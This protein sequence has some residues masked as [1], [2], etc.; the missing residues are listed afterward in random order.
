MTVLIYTDTSKQ[1]GDPTSRS[2][3]IRTPRKHG[4]RKTIPRGSPSS[5]RFWSDRI[6]LTIETALAP[7]SAKAANLGGFLPV[8]DFWEAQTGSFK[9]TTAEQHRSSSTTEETD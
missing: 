1:V 7:C 5:M 8:R 6:G 9:P 4:S 2:S 3:S